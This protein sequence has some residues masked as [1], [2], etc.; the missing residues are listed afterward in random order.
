MSLRYLKPWLGDECVRLFSATDHQDSQPK[1]ALLELYQV[2]HES[3]Q[4]L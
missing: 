1:G 2:Y 3:N 4:I